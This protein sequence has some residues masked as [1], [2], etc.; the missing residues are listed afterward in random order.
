MLGEGSCGVRVCVTCNY[1]S[2]IF[3]K[4]IVLVRFDACCANLRASVSDVCVW[5]GGHVL[6]ILLVCAF[7][8]LAFYLCLCK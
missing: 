3:L 7:V 1:V 5:V 2:I 6:F 4:S 8:V